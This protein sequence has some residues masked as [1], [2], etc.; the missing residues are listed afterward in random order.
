MLT[1]T[2]EPYGYNYKEG[3]IYPLIEQ[4]PIVTYDQAVGE[5]EPAIIYLD[6]SRIPFISELNLNPEYCGGVSVSVSSPTAD[7]I[8][9]DT[10]TFS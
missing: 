2:G 1:F 6:G 7:I 4:S 8:A 3:D 10:S 5:S 9:T